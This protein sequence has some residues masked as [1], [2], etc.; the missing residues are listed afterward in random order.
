MRAQLRFWGY[1][2]Y[3]NLA[4]EHHTYIDN[5]GNNIVKHKKSLYL[6]DICVS[7]NEN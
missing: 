5:I 3:M 4:K 2:S 7:V 6:R 1:Y